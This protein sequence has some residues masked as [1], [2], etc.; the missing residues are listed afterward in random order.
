MTAHAHDGWHMGELGIVCSNNYMTR[1]DRLHA[2][3]T[4]FA[5]HRGIKKSSPFAVRPSAVVVG[6]GHIR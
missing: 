5:V 6:N 3:L 4:T 2:L 1:F